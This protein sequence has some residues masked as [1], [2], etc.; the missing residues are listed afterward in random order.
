MLKL[1]DEYGVKLVKEKCIQF[2]M[3]NMTEEN[4]FDVLEEARFHN[5]VEL[6]AFCKSYLEKNAK[7]MFV[8]EP[9]V[10]IVAIDT[11]ID[12]VHYPRTH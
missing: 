1:S 8:S 12:F 7:T 10:V 11:A 3:R 4:V 2:V 6:Q 9:Y 5:F